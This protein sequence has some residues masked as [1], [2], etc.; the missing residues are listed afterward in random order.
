[1]WAPGEPPSPWSKSP[2]LMQVWHLL[3]DQLQ[4]E[5]QHSSTG[6]ARSDRGGNR[7][8]LW[9]WLGAPGA[10]AAFQGQSQP[11][12]LQV[13]VWGVSLIQHLIV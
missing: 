6:N 11:W 1:M 9:T 2:L 8:F 12:V 13:N 5:R 3:G 7:A 10:V 4:R